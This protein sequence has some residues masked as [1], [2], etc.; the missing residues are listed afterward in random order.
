[1]SC[2]A[3]THNMLKIKRDPTDIRLKTK[4]KLRIKLGSNTLQT[5]KHPA[6]KPKKTSVYLN[7]ILEKKK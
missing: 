1:M 4:Y 3:K 2:T 7:L 6:Y 5:I